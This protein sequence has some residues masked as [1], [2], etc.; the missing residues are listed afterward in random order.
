[1]YIIRVVTVN[2]TYRYAYS[3]EGMA[4]IK[5]RHFSAQPTVMHVTMEY[6]SKEACV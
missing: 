1:M 3:N 2:G 5:M 4:L 6:I